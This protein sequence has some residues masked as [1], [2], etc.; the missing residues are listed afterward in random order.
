MEEITLSRG[1]FTTVTVNKT[2]GVTT[3]NN[4]KMDRFLQRWKC[5]QKPTPKGDRVASVWARR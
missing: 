1:N 5:I 4:K 3:F 2:G